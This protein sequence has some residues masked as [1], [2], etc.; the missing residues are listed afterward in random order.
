LQHRPSFL[1]SSPSLL[2]PGLSQSFSDEVLWGVPHS[3]FLWAPLPLES[4]FPLEL[5]T[6]GTPYYQLDRLFG[7][8]LRESPLFFFIFCFFFFFLPSHCGPFAS[9]SS[10]DPFF[11]TRFFDLYAAFPA[12]FWNS[13][14]GSLMV[15]FPSFSYLVSPVPGYI[16][17]GR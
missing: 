8:W 17:P 1:V 14:V 6:I 4:F 12:R 11:L 9:V 2:A 16:C 13:S 10:L 5:S 7:K 15:W 3:E